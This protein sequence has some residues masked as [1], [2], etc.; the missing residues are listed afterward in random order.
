MAK[1][2]I[3]CGEQF[4]I[5]IFFSKKRNT[6]NI[7]EI[8]SSSSP[9][10]PNEPIEQLFPIRQDIATLPNPL[11]KA[12]SGHSVQKTWFEEFSW[13]KIAKNFKSLYCI[14][15][16]WAFTYS[17]LIATDMNIVSNSPF[18]WK[19]AESGWNNMK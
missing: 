3:E 1:R 12:S 15:C 18:P 16:H 10:Q 19:D 6:E 8:S 7:E 4:G 14:S 5:N 17:R 9:G 2:P 11:P 13:L